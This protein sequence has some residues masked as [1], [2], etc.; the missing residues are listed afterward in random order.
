V[1]PATFSHHGVVATAW[2]KVRRG[3]WGTSFVFFGAGTGVLQIENGW[4]LLT[5]LRLKRSLE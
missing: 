4:R 1:K 5:E 3:P 2:T